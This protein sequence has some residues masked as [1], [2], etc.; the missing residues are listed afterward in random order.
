MFGL[1]VECTICHGVNLCLSFFGSIKL[2]HEICVN[3]SFCLNYY[4]WDYWDYCSYCAGK[5]SAW[6]IGLNRISTA[7]GPF[8]TVH[9][10]V[11]WSHQVQW[12]AASLLQP[13]SCGAVLWQSQPGPHHDL[14]AGCRPWSLCG[15]ILLDLLSFMYLLHLLELFRLVGLDWLLNHIW[16]RPQEPDFICHTS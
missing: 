12:Y 6:D 14:A 10:L 13:F 2:A 5:C 16:A 11:F 15:V 9:C 3:I 4:Y 7:Q 1:A 8:L